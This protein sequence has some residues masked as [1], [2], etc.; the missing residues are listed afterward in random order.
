MCVK[1]P[2]ML[3]VSRNAEQM[4]FFRALEDTTVTLPAL[5][6]EFGVPWKEVAGGCFHI[7]AWIQ[8]ANKIKVRSTLLDA[9][10]VT[11][12]LSL[13]VD[14]GPHI[15]YW[16][17]CFLWVMSHLYSSLLLL[18]TICRCG[19]WGSKSLQAEG[20]KLGQTIIGIQIAF[21]ASRSFYSPLMQICQQFK[22]NYLAFPRVQFGR[23]SSIPFPNYPVKIYESHRL[24]AFVIVEGLDL[25]KHGCENSFRVI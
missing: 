5:N 10:E 6:T 15:L 22:L 16:V 9:N 12:L 13:P 20:R 21:L 7:I 25:K 4:T 11:L 14:K 19:N 8:C 23:D 18:S 24:E 1:L 3:L 2:C 17:G